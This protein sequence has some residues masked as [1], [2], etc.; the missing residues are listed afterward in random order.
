MES[1]RQ[2]LGAMYIALGTAA[3]DEVLE[4]ANGILTDTVNSGGVDDIYARSALQALVRSCKK[5][6]AA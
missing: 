1:V 2:M 5:M 3:G 4:R 6:E